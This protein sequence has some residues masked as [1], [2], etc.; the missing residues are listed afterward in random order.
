[1]SWW[2]CVLIPSSRSSTYSGLVGIHA[3]H[4]VD[5]PTRSAIL[6][7]K[8]GWVESSWVCVCTLLANNRKC[9][10][11]IFKLGIFHQFFVPLK[12][13]YL[14][15]LFDCKFQVIKNSPEWQF[16][17]IFNHSLSTQNV[18]NETF[19]HFQTPCTPDNSREGGIIAEGQKLVNLLLICLGV[20]DSWQNPSVMPYLLIKTFT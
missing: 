6:K 11:W 18:L 12:L 10:I 17:G 13:T 5:T 15:T 16:F 4:V 8:K 1:M 9:L 20:A 2:V 3:I 19:F 7:R 14:V